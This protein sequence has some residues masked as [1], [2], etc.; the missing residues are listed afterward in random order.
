MTP[1]GLALCDHRFVEE[2]ATAA[3]PACAIVPYG[4][5]RA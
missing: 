5:R 4:G 3:D 2:L 1:V